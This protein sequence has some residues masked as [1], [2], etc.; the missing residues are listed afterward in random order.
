MGGAALFWEPSSLPRLF[1]ASGCFGGVAVEQQ[2][3]VIG[4]AC[5]TDHRWGSGGAIVILSESVISA[6]L[7]C[8]KVKPQILHNFKTPDM[9]Y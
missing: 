4:A 9:L 5:I 1:C 6:S 8:A 2:H 7:P 3:Q